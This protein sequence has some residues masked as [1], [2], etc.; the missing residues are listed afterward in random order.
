MVYWSSLP[1]VL[2]GL[3]STF[4]GLIT[5]LVPDTA[6]VELPDTVLEAE[7][8]GDKKKKKKLAI[9]GIDNLAMTKE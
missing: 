6:N 1:I 8:L 3:A 2:F 7:H 9:I 5:F 4:A